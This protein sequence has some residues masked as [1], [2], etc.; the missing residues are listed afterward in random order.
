MT[1]LACPRTTRRMTSFSR[2]VNAAIRC[3]D[4]VFFGPDRGARDP[5][6][7][8]CE[9]VDELLVAKRLLDEIRGSGPHGVDGHRH[10]AVPRDEDDRN[11]DVLLVQPL[12]ELEPAH[13]RHT[14]VGDETRVPDG[15][16]TLQEIHRG[17]VGLER[18]ADRA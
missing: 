17:K 14:N 10:V 1:L 11:S 5:A 9:S 15:I 2:G 3:A 13:R 18:R 7:V 6:R 8:R 16:E 12:L 4:L